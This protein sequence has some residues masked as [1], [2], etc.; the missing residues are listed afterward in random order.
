[1]SVQ[2]RDFPL[3]VALAA[4]AVMSARAQ[5][6][7]LAAGP[8][9]GGA[10][11]PDFSGIWSHP[12]FPGFEPPASGPGPVVN[13][14]R[15]PQMNFDGRVLPADNDILV[16]NPAQLVGDYTNPILKPRAAE[17]V[18]RKGEMEL[19]GIVG[20]TPTIQCWP[21]PVPYIFNGVA[22]Q[23]VQQ[24]DKIIFLYPNDHQVRFVRMNQTHPAQVTPSWYGDS[25]GH[26]EGD[27]LV[28]ATVGVKIGLS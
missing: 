23:M 7:T 8:A 6:V 21:E 5:T 17:A 12:S 3:L 13:K 15:Q 4:G 18:K 24:P 14:S 19:A 27:T 11:I 1:M 28:I 9:N 20:P 22:M 16:S 10:S 2:R 26:Y 25:M